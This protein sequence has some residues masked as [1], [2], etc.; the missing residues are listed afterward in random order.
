LDGYSLI[1]MR[2]SPPSGLLVM[3][4]NNITAL[5]GTA[6]N[7]RFL[8]MEWT[9]CAT[10][11]VC[12]DSLQSGAVDMLVGKWRTASDYNGVSRFY[13][14]TPSDCNTWTDSALPIWV[15]ATSTL[16]S[17]ADLKAR[18]AT[19]TV[20]VRLLPDRAG[21]QCSTGMEHGAAPVWCQSVHGHCSVSLCVDACESD[22]GT[23]TWRVQAQCLSE[24][25]QSTA[26]GFFG[27]NFAIT[28][29]NVNAAMFQNLI[30]GTIGAVRCRCALGIAC[31]A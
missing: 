28:V 23:G 29:N 15:S 3:L 9:T 2:T 14:F 19:A 5:I 25:I 21:C 18:L 4:L 1:N 8:T 10:S 6:Y 13:S 22:S 30:D 7:R 31:R 26:R 17:I 11:N 16:N 24:G 27:S 12:F 20:S